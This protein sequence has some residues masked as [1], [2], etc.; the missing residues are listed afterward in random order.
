[1]LRNG[2]DMVSS[3]DSTGNG[4]LLLVV[5]KALSC[6]ESGATLRDLDD[7]GGLDVTA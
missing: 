7:D 5:G 2:A 6:E 1:M 3:G 4:S